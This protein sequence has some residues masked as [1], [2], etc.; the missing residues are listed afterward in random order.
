MAGTFKFELVSP[1]RV[2]MSVDATEVIVPG[3]DGLFTV[4]AGHAPVMSTLLPGVLHVIGPAGR[5][6]VFVKGGFA[7]VTADTLTVLAEQA[8]I[9]DEVD[10]AHVEAELAAA[11]K[12]LDAAND[13]EARMH[14]T[15]AIDELKMITSGATRH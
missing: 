4:M 13:D 5:K 2:L 15:R 1:E 14:I 3:A 8:F 9:T 6:A 7:D 12:A 11:Q 10:R